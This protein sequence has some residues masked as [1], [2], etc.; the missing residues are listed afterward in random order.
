MRMIPSRCNTNAATKRF[1][2]PMASTINPPIITASGKPQ[3]AVA[4]IVA[5]WE[6]FR[7][8]SADKGPIIPA[9]IPK[10]REVTSK[11]RQLAQKSFVF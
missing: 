2:I 7:L 1:F 10:D 4:V 3:K 8:N 5:N 9:R 11:A 6:A